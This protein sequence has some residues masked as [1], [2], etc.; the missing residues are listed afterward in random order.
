[1]SDTTKKIILLHSALLFLWWKNQPIYL[2][3]CFCYICRCASKFITHLAF[4]LLYHIFLLCVVTLTNILFNTLYHSSH[5]DRL[6]LDFSPVT[7]LFPPSV[8]SKA[9]ES[10]LIVMISDLSSTHTWLFG[11]G[12][13]LLLQS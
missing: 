11:F 4:I 10:F 2:Y 13:L 6:P 7:A 1:M 12:V 9:A 3:L 8:E 5:R